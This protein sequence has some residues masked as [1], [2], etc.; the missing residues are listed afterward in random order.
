M[1]RPVRDQSGQER[2]K[3]EI[4][5]DALERIVEQMAQWKKAHAGRTVQLGIYPFASNVGTALPMGDFDEAKAKAALKRIP[6]PNGG[7]AIGR[8]LEEAYKNLYRSGC[9]RKFVVCITDGENTSGPRPDHVAHE[10][11]AQT[12]GE[13]RLEFVAFDTLASQ[14][15]FLSDVNGGVVQASDGAQLQ[16]ELKQIYEQRIL[17]EKEDP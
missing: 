13:V 5:H 17:V 16:N 10:L 15:R 4:A 7:T 6:R 3:N 14:F 8:A 11:H 9:V 1:Q 12:K 2:P